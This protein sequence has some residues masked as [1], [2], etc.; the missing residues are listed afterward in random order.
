MSR[1]SLYSKILELSGKTPIE[2]IRSMKLQRAALL[3]QD[4]EMNVAQVGYAVGFSSPSYFAQAFK[5]YYHM[6]P[7]E[8]VQLNRKKRKLT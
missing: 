6:A 4:S 2:F 7:S 3:L 8:Y 5:A 1:G